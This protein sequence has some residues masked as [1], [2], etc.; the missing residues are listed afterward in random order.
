MC[1]PLQRTSQKNLIFELKK[2]SPDWITLHSFVTHLLMTF[3]PFLVFRW[4]SFRCHLQQ[5]TVAPC[6]NVQYLHTVNTLETVNKKSW[7]W[8]WTLT[9][10]LH[11][12]GTEQRRR[13][14]PL[15]TWSTPVVLEY[16]KH[17]DLIFSIYVLLYVDFWFTP[18]VNV[19]LF[20]KLWFMVFMH[21]WSQSVG[22][23][24]ISWKLC[25]VILFFLLL[26]ALQRHRKEPERTF[27]T[28]YRQC[29]L[30]CICIWSIIYLKCVLI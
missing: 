8:S 13:N 15:I 28:M 26:W 19:S 5:I 3:T 12:L 21:H 25:S 11:L 17:K 29:F 27:G 23:R 24:L 20:L 14:A 30:I 6:A 22:S 9:I 4:G 16:S 2:A 10:S 1:Q 18:Y 7:S